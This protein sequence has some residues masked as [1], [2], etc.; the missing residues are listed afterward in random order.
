MPK[1]EAMEKN[2][3]IY[4]VETEPHFTAAIRIMITFTRRRIAILEMHAA[5]KE[6]ED[7]QR[8]TIAVLET[9]E[10]AIKISK[11]LE[12]EVDILTVNLFEHFTENCSDEKNICKNRGTV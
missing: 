12:R 5:L 3:F 9:K 1:H 2:R 4:Q 8:F 10:N 7:K 11:R 6:G